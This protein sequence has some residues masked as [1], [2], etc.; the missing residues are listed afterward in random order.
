MGIA[1]TDEDFYGKLNNLHLQVFLA[2]TSRRAIFDYCVIVFYFE[3][4]YTVDSR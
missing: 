1:A 3:R 2:K 4:S